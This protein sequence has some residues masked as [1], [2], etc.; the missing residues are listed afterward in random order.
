MVLYI[1]TC[2]WYDGISSFYIFFYFFSLQV[3][4]IIYFFLACVFFISLDMF[5]LSCYVFF[6]Y[7]RI[8]CT[9]ICICIYTYNIHIYVY[10]CDKLP[11]TLSKRTYS[12][13]YRKTFLSV[14]KRTVFFSYYPT[15]EAIIVPL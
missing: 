4:S 2:I 8:R 10:L 1:Y 9:F 11:L 15:L 5:L 7:H 12:K 3:F 13:L 6:Y 14:Q